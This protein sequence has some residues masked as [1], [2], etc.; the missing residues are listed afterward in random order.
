MRINNQMKP[1][2]QWR[3]WWRRYS[4]W[5]ALAVPALT[6]LREAMP[7]LQALIPLVQYKW[8]VGVLGFVI[9]FATNI[10]Q[11]SMSGRKP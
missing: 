4:T 5:L 11:K 2:P 1:I 3:R 7:S 6:G 10:H 8:I 9:V